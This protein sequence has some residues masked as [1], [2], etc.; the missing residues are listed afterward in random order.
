M[1]QPSA[2]IL[3]KNQSQDEEQ[4]ECRDFVGKP[5]GMSPCGGGLEYL[6]RSPCEP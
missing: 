1:M 2:L 3:T 6:H 4:S 5:E